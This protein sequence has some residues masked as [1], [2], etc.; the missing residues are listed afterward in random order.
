MHLLKQEQMKV[1]TCNHTHTH[2]HTH[3]RARAP[4][5]LPAGWGWSAHA[6]QVSHSLQTVVPLLLL[7]HL[8]SSPN[9]T[10]GCECWPVP[11]PSVSAE[12]DSARGGEQSL[13][14]CAGRPWRRRTPRKTRCS[15]QRQ[16][17]I[18]QSQAGADR[19]E[20]GSGGGGREWGE[21][22]EVQGLIL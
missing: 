4:S 17:E 1:C 8:W 3:A 10:G 21:G 15:R 22:R 6:L 16:S 7:E 20:G 5:V 19:E 9:W 12:T 18:V 13:V 11:L 14:R 2:T